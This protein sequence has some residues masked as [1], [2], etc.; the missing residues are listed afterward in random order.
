MLWTAPVFF[1]ILMILAP[2]IFVAFGTWGGLL[3]LPQIYEWIL[4]VGMIALATL[5]LTFACYV[6]LQH[7]LCDDEMLAMDDEINE[8]G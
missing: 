8:Q 5:L 4:I 7:A 1:G 2:C 3:D 6:Y